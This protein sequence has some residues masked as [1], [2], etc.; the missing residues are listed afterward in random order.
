MLDI[1]KMEEGKLEIKKEQ[2][3]IEQIL[4]SSTN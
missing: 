1:A 2:L 4:G 3:A